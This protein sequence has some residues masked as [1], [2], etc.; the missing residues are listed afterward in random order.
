[1][2]RQELEKEFDEFFAMFN[3]QSVEVV[4]ADSPSQCVDLAVAFADWL[5]LPRQTNQQYYAYQ[6]Y[7]NTPA[8]VLTYMDKIPNT[9][10][11][12]PQK[13]DFVIWDKAIN[14]TAGHI[15]IGNGVGDTNKFQSFDQN[16]SNVQRVSQIVNH[17]YTHVLGALRL[18][19]TGSPTNMNDTK[20]AV[21]FDRILTFLKTQGYIASDNSNEYLDSDKLVN[22]VKTLW[23]DRIVDRPK[24]SITDQLRN[25]TG[26]PT[27]TAQQIA[28]KLK[29]GCSPAEL[30]KAEEKGRL[31]G[32]QEIKVEVS[33]LA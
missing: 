27:G 22:I 21:Q 28:D 32:R 33:K 9:P 15:G 26:L 8:Y 25:M 10:N 23:A 5:N 17:D 29:V 31:K 7:T 30:A 6:I 12:V 11:Y 19:V 3:G 24:A 14:G 16:W 2:T 1:M 18:K 4:D 13:G 20:K